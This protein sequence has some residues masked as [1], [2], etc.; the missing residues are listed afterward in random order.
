MAMNAK[1]SEMV[2]V[3]VVLGGTHVVLIRRAKPPYMDRLVMAGG[4]VEDDDA[5]LEEACARELFEEIN[6][7]V[8]PEDLALLCV[9]DDPGRDPRKPTRSTVFVAE[10]PLAWFDTC[11]AGS[12]ALELALVPLSELTPAA[13]GFD[14]WQAIA[15]YQSR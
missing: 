3:L 11:T 13:V 5:S 7:V 4:H 6:L 14:H 15:M 8:A 10:G 2:D 1:I 9:L 12:D